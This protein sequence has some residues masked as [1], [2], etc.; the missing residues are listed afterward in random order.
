MRKNKLRKGNIFIF[1][2]AVLFIFLSLILCDT[3]RLDIPMSD[4]KVIFAGCGISLLSTGIINLLWE[5]RANNLIDKMKEASNI[6]LDVLNAQNNIRYNQVVNIEF[7]KA[8]DNDTIIANI[9][10]SFTYYEDGKAGQ[11]CKLEIFSDFRGKILSPDELNEQGT[12]PDFYFIKIEE[13]D[14]PLAQWENINDRKKMYNVI[15]GKLYYSN[16]EIT[17]P[18]NE[19]KIGENFKFHI[20]NKYKKHDRLVWTFQEMARGGIK[21]LITIGEKCENMNF[22]IRLNHPK[23]K[24]IIVEHNKNINKKKKNTINNKIDEE[25]GKINNKQLELFLNKSVLPYQGFE[26]SWEEKES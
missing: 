23:V 22:Y 10:H 12:K 5:K 15:N 16:D 25:T 13:N 17:F 19:Y 1:I 4:I 26:I 20:R 11:K 3:F 6:A 2:L 8:E 7:N 21:I 9:I 24:D 14:I 18:L